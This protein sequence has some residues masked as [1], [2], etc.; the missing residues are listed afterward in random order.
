MNNIFY[1]P[2]LLLHTI[3]FLY[4]IFI[5]VITYEREAFFLPYSHFDSS[6]VLASF[7]MYI[8]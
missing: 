2:V 7:F 5:Y 6:G 4:F 3:F 8:I 1:S